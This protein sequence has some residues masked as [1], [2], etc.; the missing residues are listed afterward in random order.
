MS[1]IEND[2]ITMVSANGS[3]K[4]WEKKYARGRGCLEREKIWRQKLM[5]NLR[6]IYWFYADII[7]K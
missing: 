6:K 5:A 3:T 1:K 4:S 7:E 2:K